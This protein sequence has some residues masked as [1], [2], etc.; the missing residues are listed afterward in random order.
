VTSDNLR[1]ARQHAGLAPDDLANIVQVDVRTVRR[2][3]SGGN[4]YAR[5]RGKVTRALDIP[6]HD[7]WPDIVTPPP[8]PSAAQASDVVAAFAT[9]SD[10]AARIGRR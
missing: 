3:L 7:L 4:P 1:A 8:R 2:W 6:E 10:L 5:Q 9:A